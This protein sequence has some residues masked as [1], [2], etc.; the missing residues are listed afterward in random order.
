MKNLGFNLSSML[1][2]CYFNGEKCDISNFSYNIS[3]EYG[4]CYVF[5][6]GNLENL[7]KTSRYGLFS[8]L[9]LELYAGNFGYYNFLYA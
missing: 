1:I 6:N 2:S 5:N 7:K 4:N 8:G 9:T 3:Y